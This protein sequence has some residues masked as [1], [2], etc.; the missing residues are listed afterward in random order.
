MAIWSRPGPPA[1]SIPE[2][3]VAEPHGDHV[4]AVRRLHAGTTSR[5]GN[6]GI[7]GGNPAVPPLTGLGNR[8]GGPADSSRW[9]GGIGLAT[10]E[11]VPPTEPSGSRTGTHNGTAT[12]DSERSAVALPPTVV[13]TCAEPRVLAQDPAPVLITGHD[14]YIGPGRSARREGHLHR[15]PTR[16]AVGIHLSVHDCG[17][18]SHRT[19]PRSRPITR[20]CSHQGIVRERQAAMAGKAVISLTTGM[21]DPRRRA[22]RQRPASGMDR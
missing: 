22:S 20:R 3:G 7:P 12:G 17:D 6:L 5:E 2:S 19:L 11:T 16:S 13:A 14:L 8:V 9:T 4:Q 1:G 10:A 18:V 15:T 21:E